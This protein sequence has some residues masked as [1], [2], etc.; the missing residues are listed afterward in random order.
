MCGRWPNSVRGLIVLAIS[1]MN[2]AAQVS[3][4]APLRNQLI[5]KGMIWSPNHGDT[6]FTVPMFDEFMVRIIPSDEWRS[7]V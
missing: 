6:G 4:L 5:N 3:S 1:P 7:S 2:W